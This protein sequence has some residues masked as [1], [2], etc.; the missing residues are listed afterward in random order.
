MSRNWR[1]WAACQ[2]DKS[3]CYNPEFVAKI[4]SLFPIHLTKVVRLRVKELEELF[5]KEMLQVNWKIVYLVRDPRGVM[6]SRANL[7]W[8]HQRAEACLNPKQH[9]SEVYDDL[10]RIEHLKRQ[11]PNLFTVIKFEEF[12]S[13]VQTEAEKLFQ[14]LELPVSRSVQTFLD[15]HTH[16]DREN[17]DPSATFRHTK[18]VGTQWQ[19]KLPQDVVTNVTDVCEPLLKRLNLL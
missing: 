12:T 9:C 18:E 4:C 8:C 19:S 3:L 16:T 14:F 7:T 6:A 1:T 5:K 17:D 2:H 11:F 15:T 13:D 10:T